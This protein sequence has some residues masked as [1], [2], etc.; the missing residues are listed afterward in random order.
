MLVG[1]YGTQFYIFI[2]VSE[3]DIYKYTNKQKEKKTFSNFRNFLFIFYD[4]IYLFIFYLQKRKCG[5]CV[6]VLIIYGSDSLQFQQNDNEIGLLFLSNVS[7]KKW[8]KSLKI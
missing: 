1:F 8:E 6:F 4:E 2:V 7:P 5:K 3:W